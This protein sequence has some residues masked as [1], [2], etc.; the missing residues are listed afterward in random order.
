MWRRRIWNAPTTSKNK[1][2]T[3]NDSNPLIPQRATIRKFF[4]LTAILLL[5]ALPLRAYE[6]RFA[7]EANKNPLRWRTKIINLALS[8][9]L[10]QNPPNVKSNSDVTGALRRSLATWESAANLKFAVVWTDK[11]NI[12]AAESGG[13]GTSLITLAATPENF[14]PFQGDGSEMPGRTRIFYNS[15]GAI[16]EADV[17]LNPNQQFSTDGSF[18]TFDLEAA[19]THE[20]G[21]LLGLDHSAVLAATMFTRQG[22][23]GT[24]S[25]PGFLPRTLADDDR[26]G[27]TALY[28]TK[29]DNLECCGAIVGNLTANNSKNLFHWQVWAEDAA[30][31]KLLA[32]VSAGDAGN[33]KIGGL[34]AGK[35]RVFAQSSVY[36]SGVFELGEI[37]V[38]NQKNAVLNAKIKI[39]AR[40]GSDLAEPVFVGLNGQLSALAVPLSVTRWN[41]IYF[42]GERLPIKAVLETSPFLEIVENSL[43]LADFDAPFTI[44]SFALQIKSDA[45]RGEYNLRWRDARGTEKVLLGGFSLEED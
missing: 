3:A 33:Y 35:H 30:S 29:T 1:S 37:A 20:I 2:R 40:H 41:S 44:F 39:P 42:G 27:I 26:A 13:D 7:D 9:S 45:P 17:I 25:L 5:A 10:R 38:E 31:G 18:G 8:N 6:N 21:H 28:G 22:K 19:L 34:P 23:N 12:S 15:R 43:N 14:A 11:T 24:F 36:D 16:A 4:C 32:A